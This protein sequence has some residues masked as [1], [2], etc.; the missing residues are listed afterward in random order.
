MNNTN[1]TFILPVLCIGFLIWLLATLAFRVAGQFF[2]ITDSPL[3]LTLLYVA[4]IPALALISVFTFK[5]FKLFGLEHVVAG[6]LLVLPGM[7]IDTFVI[8]FFE[9]VF[10]NMPSGNAATFGS[11]LMWAYATVLV[12]SI[13]VGLPR[14]TNFIKK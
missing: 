7:I 13:I 5:R 11:W 8:Q 6:V 4:V 1:R 9:Y 14:N 12:S 2:F 10:P 3:V